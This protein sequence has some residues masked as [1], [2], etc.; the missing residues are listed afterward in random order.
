[1]TEGDFA[2]AAQGHIVWIDRGGKAR[3]RLD[4]PRKK[5]FL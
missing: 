5:V 4:T 1:V 3:H 2:V